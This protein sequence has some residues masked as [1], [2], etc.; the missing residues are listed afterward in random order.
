MS[1]E[2]AVD[3]GPNQGSADG[4]RRKTWLGEGV[5]WPNRG[6][7][8]VHKMRGWGGAE[9][10]GCMRKQEVNRGNF[11][12]CLEGNERINPIPSPIC[13]VK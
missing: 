6:D 3:E 13:P 1:S 11:S 10:R 8:V 2:A 12:L 5:S 7:S 4:N 9:E